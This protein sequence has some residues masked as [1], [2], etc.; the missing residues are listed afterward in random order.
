MSD[1]KRWYDHDPLLMEV[2][3]I[4]K[5]YQEELKDQAL[6]FMQKIENQV[7]KEMIDSFYNSIKPMIKGNRW[8][9]HDP[10]LSK[11]IEL[12][13]IVPPEV[14][15]KAAQGFLEALK[16]KGLSPEIL[17]EITIEE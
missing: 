14:Q 7:G 2:M 12:L 9:D 11:T 8:Y 16:R 4:L 1:F 3:E 13:R 5:N 6:V 15:K 17:Q 10:V